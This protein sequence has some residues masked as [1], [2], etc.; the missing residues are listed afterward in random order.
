MPIQFFQDPDAPEGLGRVVDTDTGLDRVVYDPELARQFAAQQS[1]DPMQ[2]IEPLQ[3][4]DPSLQSMPLESIDPGSLQ[5]IDPGSLQSIDPSLQSIQPTPTPASASPRRVSPGVSPR[6]P[7]RQSTAPAAPAA[8]DRQNA[9]QDP[10]PPSVSTGAPLPI[11][12]P[13]GLDPK[14]QQSKVTVTSGE[15]GIPYDQAAEDK[16][17]RELFRRT[18]EQDSRARAVDLI[19]NEQQLESQRLKNE[20]S[21]RE[22]INAE[23]S[24]R[25]EKQLDTIVRQEINPDRIA[26]NT[27]L[28]G[29]ILGIVGQALGMLAKPGSG[30]YRWQEQV[31]HSLDQRVQRDIDA[32]KEQKSSMINRLTAKLG[33]AQQAENHYRAQVTAYT[34]D[35]MENRLKRLGIANQYEDQIQGLRDQAMAYNEAAKAASFGK[36]GKVEVTLEQPKPVKGS[37]KLPAP[38][39]ERLEALHI[40]PEHYQNSFAKPSGMPNVTIGQATT[41]VKSLDEDRLAIEALMAENGGDLQGKDF[42]QL[43]QR[44][45]DWGAQFGLEGQMNRE[46]ANQILQRRMIDRARSLG[47][48]L[49]TQDTAA[50]QKEMGTTTTGLT[51]WL[52]AHRENYNKALRQ[53]TA[54][55]FG[56]NAQAVTNIMLSDTAATQG[57]PRP[58]NKVFGKRNVEEEGPG[59]VDKFIADPQKSILDLLDLEPIPETAPPPTMFNRYMG[60]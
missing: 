27:S 49:T 33:D 20:A 41:A 4:I 54:Q 58:P 57:V 28:G 43:P 24:A 35:I 3:S 5:S 30:I 29:S 45:S 37:G 32:Q 22:A 55:Y 44:F 8:P 38:W 40:S 52:D 2:S 15:P 25:F 12:L 56:K 60:Y 17:S 23:K 51:R 26:Q 39:D 1:T 21:K 42:F 31:Q 34:A 14:L 59:I 53:G 46:Q 47:G 16:R 11:Q 18:V 48:P 19:L 36:P 13:E 6:R 10:T 7:I 9:A 50:I